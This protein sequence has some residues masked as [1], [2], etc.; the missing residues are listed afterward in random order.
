MEDVPIF[1]PAMAKRSAKAGRP[2]RA[3]RGTLPERYFSR[4]MCESADLAPVQIRHRQ[5]N[6]TGLF[7]VSV[8]KPCARTRP[9]PAV[10]P[11]SPAELL[12]SAAWDADRH[13]IDV[14]GVGD[15]AGGGGVGVRGSLRAGARGG[16]A[17]I[18]GYG[19]AGGGV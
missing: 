12:A 13:R 4:V 11:A 14:I 6:S 19:G 1:R 18:G 7:V 2:M 3:D 15:N 17:V 9:V 16:S 8:A 5:R 10:G